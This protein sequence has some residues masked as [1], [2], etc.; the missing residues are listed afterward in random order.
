MYLSFWLCNRTSSALQYVKKENNKYKY[1]V[2]YTINS[3]QKSLK[4]VKVVIERHANPKN[5]VPNNVTDLIKAQ[6]IKVYE[7]LDVDTLN[8]SGSLEGVN[9][10]DVTNIF[11]PTIS[12]DG[13]EITFDFKD[14]NKTYILSV[15]GEN[16]RPF[17][18]G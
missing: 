16:N 9:Y 12:E 5:K 17:N 11:K 8:D 3:I 6:N 7:V 4:D 1:E 15:E 2:N 13:E 10:K 18:E 14:T